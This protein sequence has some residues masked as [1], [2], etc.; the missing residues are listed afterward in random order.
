MS[1]SMIDGHID[2]DGDLIS[3]GALIAE[4]NAQRR[5]SKTSYPKR[6]FVVGDS[7]QCI[8]T[9]PAVDAVP[10]VRCKDCVHWDVR[11]KECKNDDLSTDHEGGASHSLNFWEDDFCSYG[12]R[13]DGE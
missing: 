5:A 10:V 9:A 11:Q 3:R 8:Y 4:I 13:R 1:V 12:E 6:S 7:L 2:H